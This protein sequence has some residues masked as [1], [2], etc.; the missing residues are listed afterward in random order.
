VVLAAATGVI[1]F[2]GARRI[3][4]AATA[5]VPIMAGIYLVMGLVV[6]AMNI[7]QIPA[8]LTDIVMHAFGLREIAAGGIGTA[9]VQGM[10]RG[11]FSNEAGLGSAPN[12]AASAAVSHP[13]KQGLVQTL[14][15][16]F[17]TLIV[18]STTAFIIL[19]SD[20]YQ[21]GLTDIDGVV[22][23]QQSLV[24][25]MGAWS[26]YFLTFALLLF[27]FSS[28]MYNYYLGE[29]ALAV[30]TSNPASLHGLRIAVMGS[31]LLG[32]R[33]PGATAVFFFSDPLMGILALVNLVAIIML[34]PIAMRILRDFRQQLKAGVDRPVL[35][36]EKFADLDIDP[37]AWRHG[38]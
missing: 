11:M 31:V 10:R 12:A 16:Y 23:T 20:V 17:D 21:P 37:T 2:G 36:P 26:Q 3:A 22:L 24:S 9:I 18:C 19:L 27:A 38:R 15:V 34:F 4:R 28:I 30:M 6:V 13:V 7:D 1:I 25:H 8:V 29:N 14:G 5:L 35:S 33:A 32:A